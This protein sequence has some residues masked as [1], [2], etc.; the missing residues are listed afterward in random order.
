MNTAKFMKW[1]NE[2]EMFRLK[3]FRYAWRT[4]LDLVCYSPYHNHR[5]LRS[6]LYQLNFCIMSLINKYERG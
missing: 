4:L 6:D 1:N 2:R 3:A 5:Y